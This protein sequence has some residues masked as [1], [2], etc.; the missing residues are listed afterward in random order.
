MLRPATR[1]IIIGVACLA[2]AV[3]LALLSSLTTMSVVRTSPA[4]ADVAF[5]DRLFGLVAISRDVVAGVRSARIVIQDM[6][7]PLD[8][9]ISG[10]GTTTRLLQFDT[11]KGAV[12]AGPG[13]HYFARYADE[14]TAF[15]A[16]ANRT[17]LVASATDERSELARFL[18]A[19]ACVLLLAIVGSLMAWSGVRK[20]SAGPNVRIGPI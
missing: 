5:E 13:H 12:F 8:P 3:V 19:Q 9:A 4:T 6:K 11:G 1:S 10:Q 20:L 7:S 2:G 17:E 16:D 14:V 18:F 15:V